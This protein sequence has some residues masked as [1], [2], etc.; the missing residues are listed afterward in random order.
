M[1]EL[2]II[3]AMQAEADPLIAHM[4]DIETKTVSGIV[5]TT[6]RLYGRKIV[7]AV[8][9]IG[10]VFAALCAQSMILQFAP[11]KIVNTGVAGS[12]STALQ[13]GELAIADK[14]VQHDMDTSPLGDPKGLISGINQIYLPCDTELVE[15]LSAA[16]K[17]VKV[18]VKTGTVA[19]GDQFVDDPSRKAFIKD[20]FG[21]IAC[22]M[23][24]AA[25]GQVCF[26]NKV[27]FAVVRA[28]SDDASGKASMEYP[29][30]VQLAAKRSVALL[31]QMIERM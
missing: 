15:R 11:R 1:I 28:I 25:I 8:C 30:F 21:A 14:V 2:G 9:G 29:Q 23:E 12:L 4:T 5:F 27:P 16:A 31:C 10:K 22:E 20:A 18:T 6:G 17:D 3:A 19:S 7:V 26:V 13:I 24:G